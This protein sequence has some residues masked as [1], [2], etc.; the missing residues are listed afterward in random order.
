MTHLYGLNSCFYDNCDKKIIIIINEKEG[1]DKL[2][3]A[4][5]TRLDPKTFVPSLRGFTTRPRGLSGLY[6]SKS[7]DLNKTHVITN[8]F[9]TKMCFSKLQNSVRKPNFPRQ[10]TRFPPKS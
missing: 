1:K 10:K 2:K 5:L 7:F 9:Q 4:C 6:P 8:A 3:N